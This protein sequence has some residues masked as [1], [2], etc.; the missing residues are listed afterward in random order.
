M[1]LLTLLLFVTACLRCDGPAAN[2]ITTTGKTV[3]EPAAVP[4]PTGR[5]AS[6]RTFKPGGFIGLVTAQS[7]PGSV[8]AAYGKDALVAETLYGPEG[9]TYEGYVLFPGTDDAIELTFPETGEE[10]GV[11]GTIR[12]AGSHW[13]GADHGVRIGTSLRDL[14]RL[15]GG[16]FTFYGFE[17]DF[18]GL[19]AD[20]K[21]GKLEGH[22]M[23]LTYDW[24]SLEEREQQEVIGDQKIRSDLA[25]LA[26]A[27]VRV[28][29]I[30]VSVE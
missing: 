8:R 17:W 27:G 23:A 12:S 10:A 6:D 2:E 24:D 3:D 29:E 16:P 19:V 9:V 21:G 5:T 4:S 13:Q 15:N 1:R 20:W 7:T 30:Y 25:V 22:R 18:G 26:G 28:A 14:E 11:G